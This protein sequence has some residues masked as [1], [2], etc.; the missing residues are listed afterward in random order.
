[1]ADLA[2]I[3]SVANA[4]QGPASG[5]DCAEDASCP[6][7][8]GEHLNGLDETSRTG[9]GDADNPGGRR[10]RERGTGERRGAHVDTEK[11]VE[12]TK[13]KVQVWQGLRHVEGERWNWT[14]NNIRLVPGKCV[15]KGL[16]VRGAS[17]PSC[18]H[19]RSV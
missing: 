16:E 8:P 17:V 14:D 6:V 15:K 11:K 4:L 5:G 7:T 19:C 1:M 9:A 13:E 10:V 2:V 3:E 18:N 12:T